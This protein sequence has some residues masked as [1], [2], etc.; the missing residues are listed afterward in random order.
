MFRDKYIELCRYSGTC[1]SVSSFTEDGQLQGY[2]RA[3]RL[4]SDF[5]CDVQVLPTSYRGSAH[6]SSNQAKLFNKVP[7]QMID[8]PCLHVYFYFM[9]WGKLLAFENFT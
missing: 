5:L 7:I 4:C 3:E 8:S 9:L 6:K 1:L 2:I